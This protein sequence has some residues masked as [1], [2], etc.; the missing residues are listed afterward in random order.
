MRLK[1]WKKQEIATAIPPRRMFKREKLRTLSLF[2]RKSNMI[3]GLQELGSSDDNV[4][5][6]IEDFLDWFNNMTASNTYVFQYSDG[7]SHMFPRERIYYYSISVRYRE[8]EMTQEEID[9]ATKETEK[10]DKQDD[11]Q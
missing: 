11:A 2:D 3:G 8:F 5:T 10:T 7:G 6:T 1:F 9:Q 4:G